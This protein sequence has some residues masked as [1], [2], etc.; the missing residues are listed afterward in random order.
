MQARSLRHSNLNA[1]TQSRQ[2]NNK[3]QMVEGNLVDNRANTQNTEIKEL[4]SVSVGL[5]YDGK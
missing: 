2:K 4:R 3:L 5:D 1:R